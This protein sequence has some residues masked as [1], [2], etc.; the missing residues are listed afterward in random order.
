MR[1]IALVIGMWLLGAGTAAAFE[2]ADVTL[3]SSIVIC[4]DPALQRLADERQAA[5]NEARA[6][7][8]PAQMHA[9]WEDQK[10][11]VRSYATACGVPP[12]RPPPLPVPPAIIE[13]F[14]RAGEAR[15]AYI[16]NYGLSAGAGAAP[17]PMQG[18][19]NRVGPSFDCRKAAYPLALLLCADPRLSR[20][21]LRFNQAYWALFQQVGPDGQPGLRAEDVR[22][23]AGVRRRCG[24]PR[25]GGLTPALWQAREC[26]QS[27]YERQRQAWLARLT[28][29]A[30]Q[31][32]VRSPEQAIALQRDLQK[33]GFAPAGLIDGVY[34]PVMRAAIAAWQSAR[35]RAATGLLGDADARALEREAGPASP[36]GPGSPPPGRAP[37]QAVAMQR[38]G[39]IY[40][41][42][43]RING[44]ITLPFAVDS[45]A[46]DVLIPAD[47][48][49]TLARTGTIA[50]GDFIGDQTYT[51]AD[52]STLK[53]ARFVLRAV[54][55][56]DQEVRNVTASI[57]PVNSNPLLGQSFLSRFASWTLDN[58]RHALV[59]GRQR[60]LPEAR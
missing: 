2:C 14:R 53:S 13:C 29:A 18:P 59:L 54:Q 51:L 35:G 26:V 23:I 22:F 15:L 1:I 37:R 57:G 49:L 3:P 28:G 9:L 58:E 11:W 55:V 48:V 21:D 12:D 40:V 16:R 10:L 25:S 47:V 20:L 27:A 24:L 43:V 56:G 50:A 19:P 44:A 38:A 60:P 5:F 39:R 46:A 34:G 17:A 8:S 45:G 7:L 32:A 4:S 6:R 31:E 30:Y 36:S 42:P 41:V 33:L 52:G